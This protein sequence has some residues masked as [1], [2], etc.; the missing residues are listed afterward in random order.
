VRDGAGGA[1]RDRF[2]R[3]SGMMPAVHR[4]LAVFSAGLGRPVAAPAMNDRRNGLAV[5]GIGRSAGGTSIVKVIAHPAAG[6]HLSGHHLRTHASL[7]ITQKKSVHA[8]PLRPELGVWNPNGQTRG[9]GRAA[10]DKGMNAFSP[11][12]AR[13][14]DLPRTFFDNGAFESATGQEQ[15]NNRRREK[16]ETHRQRNLMKDE[17]GNVC[18][19]FQSGPPEICSNLCKSRQDRQK[20]GESEKSISAEAAPHTKQGKLQPKGRKLMLWTIFVILLILW[21]LG[22]FIVPFGGNLIHILLVI[23]VVVLIVNLISGRRSL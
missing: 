5:L 14:W 9:P 16:S 4:H 12:H 23:A 10:K 19:I 6:V 18:S 22:G 15:G 2:P 8:V 3:L 7:L 20:S 21:L 13:V 1:Q 17:R 11:D